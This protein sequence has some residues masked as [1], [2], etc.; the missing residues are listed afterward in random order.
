VRPDE[1]GAPAVARTVLR[2]IAATMFG[3]DVVREKGVRLMPPEMRKALDTGDRRIEESI[4]NTVTLLNDSLETGSPK[5]LEAFLSGEADVKRAGGRPIVS[6]GHDYM[7]SFQR[8]IARAFDSLS[9]AERDALHELAGILQ[10]PD[11]QEELPR[12]GFNPDGTT[13]AKASEQAVRQREAVA[14]AIMK[15][16]YR[17]GSGKEELGVGLSQ[18]ISRAVEATATPRPTH[19]FKLVELMTYIA[20]KTNRGSADAQKTF[21]GGSAEAVR[22]FL[23]GA[24]DLYDEASKRRLAVV[25]GGYGAADL[26]KQTLVKLNLG[27]N[28]AAKTAFTN[29]IVGESWPAEYTEEIQRIVNRY[30]L[31]PDFVEDTILG[32][33]YYI[34]REARKRMASALARVN[35]QP[36]EAAAGVDAFNNLYRY[37][38][39]RMTRGTF[40]LRQRYFLMNTLDHFIQMAMTAGFAPAA[41]SVTRVIVQDLMVLP[42]WQQAVALLRK[43]PRAKAISEAPLVGTAF[44][45]DALERMRRVLQSLGDVAGNRIGQFFSAAKYRVEVNPILEGLDGGFRAGGRVYTYREIRNIAV[46]EGIFA[47]F[48]TRQL[49]RAVQ[50]EG[51]LYVNQ[52]LA[53]WGERSA[54]SLD[55]ARRGSVVTGRVRNFVSDWEETVADTAEA[56]GE[57]ERLGAMVALMEA[58][59]DPRIA[60]RL[61]IDALYDYSQSMTKADR[62]IIVGIMFPFWAFQKNANA[63]VFNLMFSPWGAYRM[64]AI[65][66]ARERSAD[67]LTA[68]LYGEVSGEYEVDVE[69]M[70]PDLQDSYYALIT[71]FESAYD[72]NPPEDAKRAMR[73]LLTGRGSGV[74]DGALYQM[75]PRLL[76][77]RSEG[78][79]SDA[80]KFAAYAQL[81][82]SDA[83]RVSYLRERAGFAV[84]FPRTEAVRLYYSLLG[85]NHA[86]ME[87]FLPE[88]S[89]EAGLRHITQMAA[90]Y[91]V[92]GSFAADFFSGGALTA[93]GLREVKTMRVLEPVFDPERS[94]ILGPLLADMSSDAM[95]P[96]RLA[97]EL[98]TVVE[99][100]QSVAMKI[101]PFIGKLIDDMYGTTLLRTPADIDPFVVYEGN[102]Q[103]LSPEQQERIR[104]IQSEYP[105]AGK[106][107]DQR[108]YIPGG[109]WSMAFENTPFLGELNALLIRY[110]EEPLERTNIRGEILALSRGVLGVDVSMTSP[111]KAVKFEEP[112]KLRETKGL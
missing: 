53:R 37:M 5:A 48:D 102:L 103:Q 67:L 62:S 64:M 56:W 46:E 32:V 15:M 41:N 34:P 84:P 12:I 36:A 97:K 101:H 71:E 45:R 91:M 72:G 44:K 30:G 68:I 10:R 33:D 110:E 63:Q 13:F 57:R 47:S 25:I 86:Y 8:M 90:T 65:R 60:A 17:S 104:A 76:Q 20:G 94:P 80:A 39:T 52:E 29:W 79:F 54:G 77:M 96:K 111:A 38:K 87:V 58:G 82:P 70:P 14:S 35:Y 88:S 50:R 112:R 108:Y 42:G 40:F 66:R 26:A 61:T 51:S 27:I 93:G 6:A 23:N 73:F 24:G 2:G 7:A 69:S 9:E 31:N 74:E 21:D 85:D 19:E 83:S 75:S 109:I 81:R 11:W 98:G 55:Q 3:G 49:A 28:E 16:L 99:G 22:A 18:A 106:L 78:L 89:V 105:D 4:G 107:R 100:T 92:M 1:T 95:P 43:G 59:H